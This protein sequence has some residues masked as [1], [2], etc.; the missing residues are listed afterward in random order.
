MVHFWDKVKYSKN[1]SIVLLERDFNIFVYEILKKTTD[2]M[3]FNSKQP[4]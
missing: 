1:I 4:F 3:A 2:Q